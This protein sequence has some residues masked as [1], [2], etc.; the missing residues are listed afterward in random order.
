MLGRNGKF[1]Q[2]EVERERKQVYSEEHNQGAVPTGSRKIRKDGRG[3]NLLRLV[4]IQALL[5]SAVCGRSS[6]VSVSREAFLLFTVFSCQ[7]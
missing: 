7:A 3:D 2:R 1:Q 5:N 4:G 6:C